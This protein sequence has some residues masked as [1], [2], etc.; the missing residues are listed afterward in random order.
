M[1]GRQLIIAM[2]IG[3]F[4]IVGLAFLGV[5]DKTMQNVEAQVMNVPREPIEEREIS[6]V[7]MDPILYIYLMYV[8]DGVYPDVDTDDYVKLKTTDFVDL[9]E[10]DLSDVR[11]E[12][13]RMSSVEGLGLF[14]LSNLRRL[15]ISDNNLTSIPASTFNGITQLDYLDVRGNNLEL[16]EIGTLDYIGQLQA[17]QNKLQTVDLTNL[18]AGGTVDLSYNEIDDINSL[19]LAYDGQGASIDL[20]GNRIQNFDANNFINYNLMIG[21][22]RESTDSAYNEKTIIKTFKY[23]EQNFYLEC[24][25]TATNVV[26]NIYDESTLAPATYNIYIRTSEGYLDYV[27]ITIRIFKLAPTVSI[28]DEEG[29]ALNIGDTIKGTAKIYLNSNDENYQ[30]EY[31]INGGAYVKANYLEINTSGTYTFSV[32][33]V[34]DIGDQSQTYAFTINVVNNDSNLLQILSIM[35]SILILIGVIYLVLVFFVYRTNKKK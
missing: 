18:S 15:D 28:V 17:S 27:P 31:S 35:F 6:P 29:N 14:D 5:N 20:Y 4:M 8:R 13:L 2:T 21:F 11:D 34:S 32:R 3:V 25:N 30:V 33:A 23:G 16:L 26:T 22:Q 7:E 10:L 24:V 19:N 9:E 12:D 1:Y